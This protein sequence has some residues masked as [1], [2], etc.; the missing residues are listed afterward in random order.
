MNEM[1]KSAEKKLTVIFLC[2]FFG[3]LGIHRFYTGK[4]LTG[5]LMLLT[6]GGFGFWMLVDFASII[7]GRFTDRHGQLI[8]DWI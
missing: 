6:L 3:W 4:K 5:L 7:M 2:Y 8:V 1:P